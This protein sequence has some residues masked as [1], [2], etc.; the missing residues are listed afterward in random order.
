MFDLS[1]V[2]RAFVI[3]LLLGLTEVLLGIL[4]LR[5]LNRHVG[6]HRARQIGIGVSCLFIF[7]IAYILLPWSGANTVSDLLTLG[8]IWGCL[9]LAFDLAVGRMLFHF[10]W[11]R[12]RNDF[13]I[14]RGNLLGIGMGFVFVA[15]L[16]A[17]AIHGIL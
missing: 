14:R 1:F 13:D 12:I 3:W 6:D 11:K 16:L 5:L 17:G 4:R 9:M 15:P 10:S 8:L 7:S 2:L